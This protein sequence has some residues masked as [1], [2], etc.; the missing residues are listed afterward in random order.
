MTTVFDIGDHATCACGGSW[1][2]H[3]KLN[4]CHWLSCSRKGCGGRYDLKSRRFY[5][6]IAKLAS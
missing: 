2:N 1:V 6:S 5:A 3:C 4:V